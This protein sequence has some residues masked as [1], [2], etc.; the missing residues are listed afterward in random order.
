MSAYK[1]DINEFVIYPAGDVI[2]GY[3][4]SVQPLKFDIEKFQLKSTKIKA[5]LDK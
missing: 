1:G 4:N 3:K 5:N 2:I